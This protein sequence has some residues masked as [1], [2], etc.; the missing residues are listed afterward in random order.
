MYYR[1]IIWKG[2]GSKIPKAGRGL[3]SSFWFIVS[4][5][6]LFCGLVH[7]SDW[8]FLYKYTVGFD[9][10][11]LPEDAA[12][13]EGF[14][15]YVKGEYDGTPKTPEW[16]SRICGAPAEDI[17]WYARL[18]GKENAV[19]IMNTYAPA[20]NRGAENYPQMAMTIGLMGGHMFKPGHATGISYHRNA[21]NTGPTLAIQGSTA[22]PY[23][24]N[25]CPDTITSIELWPA[26]LNGTYHN[27]GAGWGNFT[28]IE[29][30]AIDIHMI[31]H[32]NYAYLQTG[33]NIMDGIKAHRKVDFVCTKAMFLTTQAMYSD[34][35]LPVTT[36]WERP[37]GMDGSNREALI[38]WQQV[39]EP[40]YEAKSDQ[41]IEILLM[42]KL[43]IDP[44]KAYTL[45]EKAQF[46]NQ[47]RTCTY[48]N[49]SYQMLPICTI[50]QE[51]IDEWGV[52]EELKAANIEIAPQEGAVPLKEFLE[53]GCYT[54]PRQE[55]DGYYSLAYNWA[56]FM[57]DP[58]AN[59]LPSASGKFEIY[60][61]A[62][63]DLMNHMFPGP[64][65]KPYPNYL[66][67]N[68]GYETTFKEGNPDG[69]K[70]EYP[71]LVYNPHYLRRSHSTYDNVPWLRE[72]CPN[73][74]FLSAADA[75]EKNIETGDTVLIYNKWGEILRQV[76]VVETIMPGVIAVPHGS[77]LDL[78]EETGIDRGG[79]DNV[80]CGPI[81]SNVSVAGYNNH[82]CNFEK[83]DGEALVPDCEKPQRILA[84]D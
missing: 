76:S 28:P 46:F 38:V 74:V 45:S 6:A 5:S 16:A 41:E 22:Q 52:A 55:G 83:Y 79:S 10:E 67:P 78:D 20:R 56:K 68:E 26:V 12:L 43:G 63:A 61:Q 82:N 69:K 24:V 51:D 72:A 39:T 59:P 54:V 40:L 27:V 70:G 11:H 4:N 30:R 8:D 15:E 65:V 33:V 35:V 9:A 60:C 57:Q 37:G 84:F 32:D 7:I 62:K 73:P 3:P 25:M 81:T 42:K 21:G 31:Y 50:T 53:R 64:E 44:A 2:I 29:E 19:M 47:L 23:V 71:Y 36:M 58:D 1:Q 77:W 17:T 18:I 48:L 14:A 66:V 34:I 49:P 13:S 80:L 75:K